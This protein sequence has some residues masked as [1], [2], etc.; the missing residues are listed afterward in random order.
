MGTIE[1]LLS[2]VRQT[3]GNEVELMFHVLVVTTQHFIPGL[4][5]YAPSHPEVVY[6]YLALMLLSAVVC[7]L[8]C[9]VLARRHAFSR[10][11][12]ASWAALGLLF[13]WA[14]LALMLALE[15]WP[16][17][18]ACPKCHK[19]RVVTR[20]T[21]EHCGAVHAV[22]EPDGTE[23]FEVATPAPVAAVAER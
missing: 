3:L 9:F 22:P 4:R 19:L 13:G 11:S 12:S 2:N 8:V 16:A 17:R 23:I 7:A 18:I 15:E 14:G 6:S 21:C 20:E 10:V 1:H 5:W